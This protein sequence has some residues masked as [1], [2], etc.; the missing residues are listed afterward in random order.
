MGSSADAILFYGVSVDPEMTI[1]PCD[2]P[3]EM[4]S[5]IKENLQ[6]DILDLL[7]IGVNWHSYGGQP[8]LYFYCTLDET[9]HQV[10]CLGEPLVP[11][12]PPITKEVLE[13]GTK[14]ED[15]LNQLLRG[16]TDEVSPV[17]WHL[18]SYCD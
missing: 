9:P 18:A 13:W 10:A 7:D 11:R 12:M 1:L 17:S 14:I 3:W 8:I 6:H 15:F 4:E 16:Q 5:Y 2:D